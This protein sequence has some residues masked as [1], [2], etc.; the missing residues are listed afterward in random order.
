MFLWATN[1]QKESEQNLIQKE[2]IDNKIFL[3]NYRG[4]SYTLITLILHMNKVYLHKNVY[5][6]IFFFWLDNATK[7]DSQKIK[8][9]KDDL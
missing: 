2:S 6:K 9:I 7:Q 3:I 1:T 8:I 4:L 5:Q